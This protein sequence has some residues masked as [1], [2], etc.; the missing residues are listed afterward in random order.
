MNGDV[1]GARLFQMLGFVGSFGCLV[2]GIWIFF[3]VVHLQL[4][5]DKFRNL[6]RYGH[7]RKQQAHPLIKHFCAWF[8]KLFFLQKCS[9]SLKN[10]FIHNF[11]WNQL[12]Q[13]TA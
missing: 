4:I 2:A 12:Y 1:A 6:I 10:N 11:V 13:I 5:I 3:A 8:Q 9:N 7:G